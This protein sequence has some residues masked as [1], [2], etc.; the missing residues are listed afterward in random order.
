MGFT[1]SNGD[2]L[3]SEYLLPRDAAV[4]AIEALRAIG[5]VI[6]P[7]LQVSEIRTVAADTLWMSTAYGRDSVALHS[8]WN[9]EPI[10]DVLLAVESALAP[11]DPR[12][13]WGKRFLRTPVYE[14]QGDFLELRERL[15]PRGAFRNPWFARTVG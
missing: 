9:P 6:A 8:T 5:A 13:H 12:P 7:R 4:P 2:E 3:Q 10:D 11:F 15:D 14:R 1:P